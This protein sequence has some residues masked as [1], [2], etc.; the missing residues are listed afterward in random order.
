MLILK[1][2]LTI[3]ATNGSLTT[4]APSRITVNPKR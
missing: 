3:T 1:V 2:S 4:V